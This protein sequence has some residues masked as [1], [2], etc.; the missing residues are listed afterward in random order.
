M[1]DRGKAKTKVGDGEEEQGRIEL[2]WKMEVLMDT[3]GKKMIKFSCTGMSDR[4]IREIGAD[5]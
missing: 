3:L 5:A 2:K 4:L 1:G